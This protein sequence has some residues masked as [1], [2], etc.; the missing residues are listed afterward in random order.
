MNTTIHIIEQLIHILIH[1]HKCIIL[2]HIL[3]LI[4]KLMILFLNEP[5]FKV[6]DHV[7]MS[8]YKIFLLNVILQISL[9]KFL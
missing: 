4:K 9:K 1:I 8:K 5:K 7:R 2:T 3:I 6:D